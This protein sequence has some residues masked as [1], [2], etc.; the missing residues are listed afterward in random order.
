MVFFGGFDILFI[1]G[2]Y[3]QKKSVPL[4]DNPKL[5]LT[6]NGLFPIMPPTES[7]SSSLKTMFFRAIVAH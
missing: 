6:L 1:Y 4:N 3:H 5:F 7:E 2:Q